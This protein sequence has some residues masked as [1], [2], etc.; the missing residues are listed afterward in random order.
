M[1]WSDIDFN[2]NALTDLAG[3]YKQP[4]GFD[5]DFF[6]PDQTS[7]INW[8]DIYG[9]TDVLNDLGSS[10]TY[11]K[12]SNG[13]NIMDQIDKWVDYIDREGNKN[14]YLDSAT[15]GSGSM[16]LPGGAAGNSWYKQLTPSVGLTGV[17]RA[18]LGASNLYAGAQYAQN[19]QQQANP[20]IMDYVKGGMRMAG[21]QLANKALYAI[22]PVLGAVNQFYPGGATEAFKDVTRFAGDIG[23]TVASGV[24]SVVKGA[25]NLVKDVIDWFCDERLKVDIAPLES[26]EVNDELAQMAF[27][28]KGLR[29]CS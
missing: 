24:G 3:S 16:G 17:N 8:A 22:N 18:L 28:V 19:M 13:G 4:A 14:A 7:N 10:Y 29:E 23:N 11:N 20:G 27:F 9:N 6:S 5:V 25:G 2:S 15:G 26:T 12:S 21:S 1:N